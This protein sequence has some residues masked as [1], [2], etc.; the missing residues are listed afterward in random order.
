MLDTYIILGATGVVFIILL[1][2]MLLLT[3][4]SYYK[5]EEND[6]RLYSILDKYVEVKQQKEQLP[7]KFEK[8]IGGISSRK[9]FTVFSVI[10]L[11]IVMILSAFIHCCLIYI[12]EDLLIMSFLPFTH[13]TFLIFITALIIASIFKPFYYIFIFIS[14]LII[15][16][17]RQIFIPKY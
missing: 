2:S 6:Y 10:L 11:M 14:W 13:V 7:N 4:L 5:I 8:E 9:L 15:K 12:N 3:S 17:K 16:V 1:F